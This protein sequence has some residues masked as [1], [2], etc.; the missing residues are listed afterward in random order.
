MAHECAATVGCALVL[1]HDSF[2]LSVYL[3]SAS[4][5]L[6]PSGCANGAYVVRDWEIVER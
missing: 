5:A 1:F 2:G 4:E 3:A 6:E